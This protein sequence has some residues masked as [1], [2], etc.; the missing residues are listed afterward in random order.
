MH[1]MH[2]MTLAWVTEVIRQ[3][4]DTVGK[5]N[6]CL[7]TKD[8]IFMVQEL[9]LCVNTELYNKFL[10]MTKFSGLLSKSIMQN[11]LCIKGFAHIQNFFLCDCKTLH[12]AH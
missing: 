7:T 9:C 11:E 3:R 12:K 4:F 1:L 6:I 2:Y 5:S 10:K 8:I